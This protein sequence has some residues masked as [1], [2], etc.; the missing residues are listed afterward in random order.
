[1]NA[2]E[3][4]RRFVD[5]LRPQ[6]APIIRRARQHVPS[7]QLHFPEQEVIPPRTCPHCGGKGEVLMPDTDGETRLAFCPVCAGTGQV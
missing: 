5:S 1:M 7:V 6:G 4:L 3:L 2:R